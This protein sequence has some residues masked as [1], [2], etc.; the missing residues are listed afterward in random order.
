MLPVSRHRFVKT[1][2]NQ[3]FTTK[4]SSVM[5]I[6]C[7]FAPCLVMTNVF[8]MIPVIDVSDVFYCISFLYDS[9]HFQGSEEQFVKQS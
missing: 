3:V 8:F 4:K 2:S 5:C 1:A 9:K 6:I 7:I